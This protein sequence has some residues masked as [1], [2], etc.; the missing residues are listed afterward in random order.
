[1]T[2]YTHFRM[3]MLRSLDQSVPQIRSWLTNGGVLLAL[4]F[5]SWLLSCLFPHLTLKGTYV[6]LTPIAL[7]W[8]IMSFFV[9][10]N[11]LQGII[12]KCAASIVVGLAVTI[13]I[14]FLDRTL[15]LFPSGGRILLCLLLPGLAFSVLV[16]AYNDKK[17][18]RDAAHQTTMRL[19][20]SILILFLM[21]TIFLVGIW[22]C[23]FG[24]E[25]NFSRNPDEYKMM[26]WVETLANEDVMSIPRFVEPGIPQLERDTLLHWPLWLGRYASALLMLYTYITTGETVLVSSLIFIG[27]FY[28]LSTMSAFLLG[29]INGLKTA[30]TASALLAFNPM[31]LVWMNHIMLDIPVAAAGTLSIYFFL[32]ALKERV[33]WLWL[34]IGFLSFFLAATIRPPMPLIF[35]LLPVGIYGFL[36]IKNRQNSLEILARFSPFLLFIL[37]FAVDMYLNFLHNFPFDKSSVANLFYIASLGKVGDPFNFLFASPN[38]A[39]GIFISPYLYTPIVAFLALYGVAMT[40]TKKEKVEQRI[41]C[42]IMILVFLSMALSFYEVNL[43]HVM[44]VYPILAFFGAVGVHSTANNRKSRVILLLCAILILVIPDSAA[45]PYI[46]FPIQTFTLGL[47]LIMKGSLIIGVAVVTADRVGIKFKR[48]FVISK[49]HLS[50]L[51]LALIIALAWLSVFKI[52]QGGD[53]EVNEIFGLERT[54]ISEAVLW[55]KKNA[56]RNSTIAS[57][58]YFMFPFYLNLELRWNTSNLI[59]LP[60]YWHNETNSIFGENVFREFVELGRNGAIDYLILFKDG[61]ELRW[62]DVFAYLCEQGTGPFVPIY[63]DPAGRFT[64]YSPIIRLKNYVPLQPMLHAGWSM[65]PRSSFQTNKYYIENSSSST[66]IEVAVEAS[67]LVGSKDSWVAFSIEVNESQP[68]CGVYIESLLDEQTFVQVLALREGWDRPEE[69]W[70]YEQTKYNVRILLCNENVTGGNVE[71]VFRVRTKNGDKEFGGLFLIQ[72]FNIIDF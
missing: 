69:L 25:M 8:S 27:F 18:A 71:Y 64:V 36:T 67:S 39:Y 12:E 42:F 37:I 24:R 51:L 63:N 21:F 46:G 59:S 3:N 22:F 29:M 23:Q 14:V 19:D 16:T 50:L 60:G 68:H 40:V 30:L 33:D 20:R 9:R 52:T 65:D 62:N 47:L 35:I 1:M 55:V 15:F 17:S 4:V 57:N 2:P 45:V 53:Y 6:F 7:G 70:V 10:R 44:L 32:R 13:V 56:F 54:G 38:G 72:P 66:S 34:S 58:S 43:R 28:L 11:S 48:N 5:L 26:F 31:W 49:T 41:L 61:E